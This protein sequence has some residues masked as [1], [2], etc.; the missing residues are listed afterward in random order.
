RGWQMLPS[1]DRVYSCAA[2]MRDLG[3]APRNDFRAALARLAEGRDY[4]SDLAIA[5]GSKGYHDEVFEDGP[6][7]VED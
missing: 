5:V 2:A 6:F 7:P 3:W 4:R 1:V